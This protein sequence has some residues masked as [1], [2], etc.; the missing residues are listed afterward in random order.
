MAALCYGPRVTVAAAVLSSTGIRQLLLSAPLLGRPNF[1]PPGQVSVGVNITRR[2]LQPGQC[3]A[4]T[5]G[6]G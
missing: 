5:S 1:D 3:M 4:P 2:A 6:G